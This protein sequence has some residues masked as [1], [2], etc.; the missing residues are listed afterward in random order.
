VAGTTIPGYL[1]RLGDRVL[2]P[3][4]TAGTIEVLCLRPELTTN[5][6]FESCASARAQQLAGLGHRGCARIRR[7]GRLAAPDGR[8]AVVSEWTQGWR[9][10]EVLDA[11]DS[12]KSEVASAAAVYLIFQALSAVAA[13]HAVGP[14]VSHGALSP[15][16]FLVTPAGRLMV[17]EH[18]FGSALPHL[19]E[20]SPDR[21]WK[22]LRLAV[23]AHASERFGRRTDVLQLGLTA[24]ALLLGRPLRRDEYPSRVPELLRRVED[25]RREG[26]RQPVGRAFKRWLACAIGIDADGEHWTLADAQHAFDQI[27]RE[28]GGYQANPQGLTALLDTAARYYGG[29]PPAP[30]AADVDA[31]SP[32]VHP[33]PFSAED[34]GELGA[35][36]D[37]IPTNPRVPPEVEAPPDTGPAAAVEGGGPPRTEGTPETLQPPPDGVAWLESAVPPFRP[38]HEPPLAPV[39]SPPAEPSADAPARKTAEIPADES[40]QPPEKPGS[41]PTLS[42]VPEEPATGETLERPSASVGPSQDDGPF[43]PADRRASRRPRE[44]PVEEFARQRVGLPTEE[45]V[46]AATSPPNLKHPLF[47]GGMIPPDSQRAGA[48]RPRFHEALPYEPEPMTPPPGSEAL[49]SGPPLLSPDATAKRAVRATTKAEPWTATGTTERRVAAPL[50][51]VV[52]PV[53][54][55]TPTHV[56]SVADDPAT[57]PPSESYSRPLFGVHEDPA[58][59]GSTRARPGARMSSLLWIALVILT[60]LAATGGGW[61]VLRPSAPPARN[62]VPPRS[63][64]VRAAPAAAPLTA[65][66]PLSA[67]PSTATTAPASPAA[68]PAAAETPAREAATGALLVVCSIP[69]DVLDR[70]Q[71]LGRSDAGPLRLPVGRHTVVLINDDLGFRT[72]EPISLRAGQTIRIQPTLPT[73]TANINATPWAEVFI[74]GERV[75]D[76]PLGNIPL[77]IGPHQVQFRH[78]DFGEQTRTLV[79]T[80][81]SIARLSVEMK[82]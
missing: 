47:G 5:P 8:L 4:R 57:R 52:Q 33:A 6:A 17:L 74:D 1:D 37:Q 69:L 30:A 12:E 2:V 38:A 81:T 59:G 27:V 36:V 20:M 29:A 19:P 62:V 43:L 54:P 22:D 28:T 64:S 32:V 3:D 61:Y 72:T 60:L 9:L 56:L 15:E 49:S 71:K 51:E 45:P 25:T 14:D 23:P 58:T 40:V 39:E 79:V 63:R 10:A 18:V 78:P 21:V 16:R 66:A 77:T 76:T 24:L 80:T 75:G 42:V 50:R 11:V 34:V 55:V 67:V 13:L 41:G 26:V 46:S 35:T 48:S 7:V 65:P 70:G 44:T 73:G 53:P 31:Q 68:T 82:Q